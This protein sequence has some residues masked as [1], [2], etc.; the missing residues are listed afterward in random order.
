MKD[1]KSVVIGLLCTVLC[2]MAVAY[3]AFSTSLT[4]NGTASIA[5]TWDVAISDIECDVVEG[6]T[7]AADITPSVSGEL[8]TT[9]TI[10][11]TFNQPGDKM[12]CVVTITNDGDL[13]A[14]LT[15]IT[16]TPE[17]IENTTN[18]GTSAS[19]FI[20]YT[21]G[22]GA[23]D[24]TVNALLPAK[25]NHKYT[26]VAEYKNIV[27]DGSTVV[28]SETLSRQVSVNFNYVQNLANNG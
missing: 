8:T 28:P 12:T 9:A 1:S 23:G 25:Q 7:G 18:G 13:E 16:T 4:I 21:L 24:V 5:S 22:Q 11:V 10:G 2:I 20:H 19:D 3:A 6:A 14:K 15:S 27:V 17:T 26:I